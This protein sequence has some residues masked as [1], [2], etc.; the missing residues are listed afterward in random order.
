MYKTSTE[1]CKDPVTEQQRSL[2]ELSED[3]LTDM[4]CREELR[5]PDL[6]TGIQYRSCS[7]DYTQCPAKRCIKKLA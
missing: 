2:R 6:H 1:V 4:A 5:S 3:L 7:I